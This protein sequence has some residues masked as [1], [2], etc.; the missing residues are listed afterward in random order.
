MKEK[1]EEQRSKIQSEY[2]TG[3]HYCVDKCVVGAIKLE[4]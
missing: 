2:C 4:E 3:C 1:E